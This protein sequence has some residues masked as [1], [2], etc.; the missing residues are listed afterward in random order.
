VTPPDP[1]RDLRRAFYGLLTCVGVAVCV[2]KIAGVESLPEPSRYNPPTASDFGAD[3]DDVPRRVWPATRPDPTPMFG[4]NDKSRFATVKALVEN[5]T[6][7]VGRRDNFTAKTGYRDTGVIFEPGYGSLDKVMDPDTGEFYSSKPPLFPTLVAGE[8]WVLHKLGLSI[9]RDRWWV[10]GIILLTF[11]ALPFAVYLGLLASLIESVG[12]TD[13]GKLF[14]FTVAATA[15]FLTT[16]SVTLNNH[17]PAA[18]CVVFALYPLLRSGA[19]DSPPSLATAG[20]FAGLS[21][22]FEL[23]AASLLVGLFVPL[24]V[25]RRGGALWYAAGAALPLAAF[26][27]ANYAAMGRWLPAYGEFGGPWYDFPGSHW[28]K[29]KLPLAERVG[30]GIDFASEPKWLYAFH[31]TLG[32]HGWFSLT[33]VWL[34]GLGGLIASAKSSVRE[35]LQMPGPATWA[36]AKL[37]TLTLAVSGVVFAFY[38]AR[39]NNYGGFTSCARWLMWLTPL[40]LLGTLPAADAVGRSRTGRVVAGLLLAASV[41]SVMYP[42]WNPWRP[43]WILQLC[44]LMG[45]VRY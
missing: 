9:D 27:A 30:L 13:F 22:T 7:V 14:A 4:S 17:T 28:A 38:V 8:Y 42:A 44:E 35:S 5:G 20:F 40:W 41:F 34:L 10:V 6:Y 37:A 18:C 43:P 45:W 31:L 16:F 3:R 39:T 24:L 15:T 1:T 25:A 12:R 19:T 11:N 33:P 23:P 29:L 32:H 2:A 26:F 36:P 21:T